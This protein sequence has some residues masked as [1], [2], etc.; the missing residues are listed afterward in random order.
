MLDTNGLQE[1]PK[2][3]YEN[4]AYPFADH[5]QL[6]RAFITINP[7]NGDLYLFSRDYEFLT[8][9]RENGEIEN[10]PYPEF[11]DPSNKFI[12]VT[13]D[14]RYLLFWD[15]SIGRV[16]R[17]D[18]ET[19]ELERIDNSF[20]HRNMYYPAAYLDEDGTIYAAGGYGF[21]EFKNLLIRFDPV[22]G[23]WKEIPAANRES[24][25]KAQRGFLVKNEAGFHYLLNNYGTPARHLSPLLAWQ[26][27]F[28]TGKWDQNRKL[29]RLV[30]TLQPPFGI[31]VNDVSIFT[32]SY[33]ADRQSGHYGFL[34]GPDSRDK[35]FNLLDLQNQRLFTVSVASLGLGS[36]FAAFYSEAHGK[37][38]ILGA[39][40][41]LASRN[42]MIVR[43]FHFDPDDP[44]FSEVTGRR[45]ALSLV[46]G[47]LLFVLILL[48][49]GGLIF[50][51]KI[52]NG[53]R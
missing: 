24:L 48:S 1:P 36:V 51:K 20:T 40:E 30:S 19:L 6:R 41:A 29:T 9:I 14:G 10:L 27:S 37:W 16:H 18:L 26:Y 34:S 28:E 53:I 32:S 7:Q 44:L 17:M 42:T 21:W 22:S 4:V 39:N 38:I 15:V 33:T 52:T 25:P 46:A 12:D 3:P 13:R 45:S 47:T 50:R 8:R 43:T 5:V 23:E 2:V 31:S 35:E 11:G 49:A